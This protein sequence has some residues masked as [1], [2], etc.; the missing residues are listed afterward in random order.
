VADLEGFSGQTVLITGASRGIGAGLVE[1]FRQRGAWVAGCARSLAPAEDAGGWQAQVDVT[2]EAA[3]RAWIEG[4][5]QRRARID[6]LVNNAGAASMNHALLTPLSSLRG[7]F[8]LNCLAAFAASREV[9][10]KM[11][12][13]GYGRIVNLTTVAV[14]LRLAGELAYAASKA[15]LESA[16]RVLATELA[17]YGITCN[18]VGPS[19]V[20]TDLLRGVPRDKLDRLLARLPQQRLATVAEVAYAVELFARREA[21]ALTG[22]TLSLGGV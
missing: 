12:K 17:P 14:P 11:R 20:A 1:H 15:A 2:D 6:V 22:Q 9:A 4:V 5:W 8:E 10:K 7:A 18:L 3:V 16:T 21:S 13:A 19:P